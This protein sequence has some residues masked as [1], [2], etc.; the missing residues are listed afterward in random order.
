MEKQKFMTWNIRIIIVKSKLFLFTKHLFQAKV[1]PN[2][3]MTSWWYFFCFNQILCYRSKERFNKVISTCGWNTLIRFG[4]SLSLEV[5]LCLKP[6][7]MAMSTT[8]RWQP[9]CNNAP[10][11]KMQLC[12]LIKTI[13]LQILSTFRVHGLTSVLC[14]KGPSCDMKRP[15]GVPPWL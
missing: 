15:A 1:L 10:K 11:I 4:P 14:S 2:K 13:L 7:E 6:Q 5:N 12:I 8:F 3:N 9:S